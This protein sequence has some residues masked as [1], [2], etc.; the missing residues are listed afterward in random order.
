VRSEGFYV[1][2]KSDDTSWDR[3]SNLPIY[4]PLG[5]EENREVFVRLAGLV[6]RFEADTLIRSVCVW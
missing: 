1:N 4:S 2:E 6:Q 5:A 3:T